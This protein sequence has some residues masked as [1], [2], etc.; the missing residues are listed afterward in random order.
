[1]W[2]RSV[3]VG[4]L[5]KQSWKKTFERKTLSGGKRRSRG[6]GKKSKEWPLAERVRCPAVTGGKKGFVANSEKNWEGNSKGTKWGF[7]PWLWSGEIG[8]GVR[9]SYRGHVGG[10]RKKFDPRK[11]AVERG[12]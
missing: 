12:T 8:V 2:N 1:L 5:G 4:R 11:L 7:T 3:T 9:N 10:G 6:S